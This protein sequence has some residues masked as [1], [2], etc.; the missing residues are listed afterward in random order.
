M[1]SRVS[2]MM[3]RW[4][5]KVE[6]LPSFR[7][8]LSLREMLAQYKLLTYSNIEYHNGVLILASSVQLGRLD[9]LQNG[10][11]RELGLTEVDAFLAHSF[12]PLTLRRRIGVPGLLHKRV[13]SESHPLLRELLP[14]EEG[15]SDR[16]NA[17]SLGS[18]I[19]DVVCNKGVFERSLFMYVLMYNKLPDALVTCRLVK[20]FQHC[21]S[22]E[23]RRR[24]WQD[25]TD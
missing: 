1:I 24:V 18:N 20:T 10:F 22:Q 17:K 12:A 2:S 19:E 3:S 14:L 6:A 13:L 9:R 8:E 5:R 23:V 21:L 11:L 16:F 4:D 25:D 7:N 15:H